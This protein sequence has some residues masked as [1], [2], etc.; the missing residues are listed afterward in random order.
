MVAIQFV[1]LLFFRLAAAGAP[2]TFDADREIR[3]KVPPVRVIAD[4][5]V[6]G[7]CDLY[8]GGEWSVSVRAQL[9]DEGVVLNGW[10]LFSENAGDSTQ[11]RGRFRHFVSFKEHPDRQRWCSYRLQ[12]QKGYMYGKN[13]GPVGELWYNG[14][15]LI[16]GG[17]MVTDTWDCEVGQAGGVLYFNDLVIL[18]HCEMAED[19]GGAQRDGIHFN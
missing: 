11:I 15:G 1:L 5:L 14:S 16:K 12:G 8:G 3:L 17:K 6:Q 2:S 13:H 18:S 10:L 4:Q 9:N 19:E 7:D